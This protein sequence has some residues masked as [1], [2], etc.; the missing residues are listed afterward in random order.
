[1]N[2][3]STST[4]AS[5]ARAP[6]GARAWSSP[7]FGVYFNRTSNQWKAEVQVANEKYRIGSFGSEVDAAKAYDQFLLSRGFES[8][9]PLNFGGGGEGDGAR[10]HRRET[11]R[12]R[13]SPGVSP[14]VSQ[15]AESLFSGVEWDARKRRWRILLEA[16]GKSA[17]TRYFDDECEAAD[18]LSAFAAANDVAAP[19][20]PP[21]GTT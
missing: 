10:K 20:V 11:K 16:P 21:A 17:R 5:G 1:M 14:G 7:F 6:S 19:R 2:A 8:V 13:V 4:A 12:A 15:R 18:A 3:S 9:R